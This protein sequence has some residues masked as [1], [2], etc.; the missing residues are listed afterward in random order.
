[1]R[2]WVPQRIQ[3]AIAHLI[4]DGDLTSQTVWSGAWK[5][6]INVGTRSLQLIVL[7]V[8]G[9]L[10]A[11]RDFGLMGIALLV[12][13]GMRRFSRL[14]IKQALIQHEKDD[15]DRYLD[16]VF[17]ISI[18][19]GLV[20]AALILASAPLVARVF[21]E[22]RVVPLLQF[23]AI[24]PL[25]VG[26]VNPGTVYFD[27]DL[28]FHKKFVYE[29]GGSIVRFAVAI[30]WAY[31][32]RDVWA[33]VV[34]YVAANAVRTGL[35]YVIHPY[36]PRLGL[37]TGMAAELLHYGKWITASNVVSFLLDEGDDA[38]VGGVIGATALGF[39]KY[40]YRIG[41]APATEVS[42]VIGDVMFSS[43]SK[44][45]D[46]VE[47]LESAL[48]RTIRVT[49]AFSFP[50][51][52]GIVIVAPVFVRAF[53]G[54]E[55]LPMIRV[56]QLLSL[57]GLLVSITTVINQIWKATGRPDLVTKLGVL[58]LVVL[59]VFIF[60]AAEFGIEA[61]AALISLVYVVVTVPADLFLL[62]RL[63]DIS[64]TRL[65][66]ELVYPLSASLLMGTVVL[67]ARQVIQLQPIVGFLVLVS[68]GVGTYFP[69]ALVIDRTFD[70]GIERD[71]AT[72]VDTLKGR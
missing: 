61:V 15:V 33:L 20:L 28:Q 24:S 58:R 36:R 71:L 67:A 45:Q 13:A 16:T 11:P 17:G 25:F 23:L 49:S 41:N 57:Y 55:W 72:I 29:M 70:W 68:L 63:T 48:I 65:A 43:F 9:N 64:P 54:S 22:P 27:K 53:L 21:G 51:A 3:T 1:M 30:A 32:Y 19:R 59:A 31:V 46:D 47:A 60:P 56:M 10:L 69:L 34:G 4:P 6:A 44:L 62:D 38:V 50:T 37:D 40:G 2:N 14:G 12:L 42:R 26:V 66:A 39:Y 8:L 35:S 52:I 5:F 7:I 18:A